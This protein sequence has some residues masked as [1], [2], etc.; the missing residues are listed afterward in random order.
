MIEKEPC[1]E[2]TPSP[3]HQRE[4]STA[5]SRNGPDCSWCRRAPLPCEGFCTLALMLPDPEAVQGIVPSMHCQ[6]PGRAGGMA[7]CGTASGTACAALLAWRIPGAGLERPRSTPCRSSNSPQSSGDTPD[8]VS[9]RWQE[10]VD[11]LEHTAG[12]CPQVWLERAITGVYRSSGWLGLAPDLH[13]SLNEISL[14]KQDARYL[15]RIDV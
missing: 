1:S 9:P 8:V 5:V 3:T 4:L 7:G 14:W 15:G 12:Q 10:P 13:L 6:T 2:I 11:A